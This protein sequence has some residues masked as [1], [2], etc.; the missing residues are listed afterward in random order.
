MTSKEQEEEEAP[1]EAVTTVFLQV[2][3]RVSNAFKR[4]TA[5]PTKE[6]SL[7]PWYSCWHWWLMCYMKGRLSAKHTKP[8]RKPQASS[9]VEPFLTLPPQYS[10]SCWG[11]LQSENYFITTS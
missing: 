3:G 2:L 9:C 1:R 11:Y 8:V 6:R 5:C 10:S 4:E 7:P